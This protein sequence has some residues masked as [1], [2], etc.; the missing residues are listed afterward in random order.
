MEEDG[1]C[2]SLAW[3]VDVE[4]ACRVVGVRNRSRMARWGLFMSMV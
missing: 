2:V 4:D 3:W 1:T